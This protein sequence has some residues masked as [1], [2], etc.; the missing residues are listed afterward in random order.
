ME[1]GIQERV[2][3]SVR[4]L[5]RVTPFAR[6]LFRARAEASPR[7]LHPARAAALMGAGAGREMKVMIFPVKLDKFTGF[8][9]KFLKIYRIGRKVIFP[10]YSN[11]Y[12]DNIKQII[13]DLSKFIELK[14][15]FAAPHLR[16][17]ARVSPRGE[18]ARPG[19][20]TPKRGGSAT[21]RERAADSYG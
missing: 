1:S 11:S 9:D 6:A 7:V 5:H 16:A 15:F 12:Q 2:R 20:P 18:P 4:V 21:P 3:A 19:R 14:S 8:F 10:I 13:N 17:T